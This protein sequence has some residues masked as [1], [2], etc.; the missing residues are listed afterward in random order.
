MEEFTVGGVPV[1][2]VQLSIEN[3]PTWLTGGVYE[4]TVGSEKKQVIRAHWDKF[5]AFTEA[6]NAYYAV[7]V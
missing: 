1:K 3:K 5:S 6:M 2:V 7:N 4:V